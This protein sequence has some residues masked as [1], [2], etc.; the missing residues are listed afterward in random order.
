MSAPGSIHPTEM[1]YTCS[2]HIGHIISVDHNIL[3]VKGGRKKIW[4]SGANLLLQN[5]EDQENIL[6]LAGMGIFQTGG[7]MPQKN[8]ADVGKL[9]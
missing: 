8:F 1:T 4:S 9:K 3:R 2:L 7:T 5:V 6:R